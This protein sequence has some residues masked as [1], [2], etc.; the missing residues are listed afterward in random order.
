MPVHRYRYVP[1]LRPKRGERVGIQQLT[2]A[3]RQEVVPLFVLTS[4]RYVGKAQT[5]NHAAVSAPNHFVQEIETAWSQAPFYLDASALP[6]GSGQNPLVAIANRARARN[7]NLIPATSMAAIPVYQQAVNHVVN[8]DHRGVALRIGLQELSTA[9][10]WRAGWPHPLDETDLIVDV[11]AN[12]ANVQALGAGPL[13]NVFRNLH[14]GTVWRT[15][16]FVGTSMPDN[17]QGYLAGSHLLQRIEWSIW[18][19]LITPTL[20]HRLPYTLDYGDYATVPLN[21]PPTG[22][23]WG[24]PINVRYTLDGE[25]LICRGVNTTGLGAVDMDQQL[26]AH[27]QQIVAF[28]QRGPLPNCWADIEIDAIATGTA[29]AGNL[30]HWVQIGVN[31]H[32]ERVRTLLP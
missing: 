23:R 1:I 31:R 6:H 4:D 11:G 25:F 7:L 21:P 22:I 18:Q 28:P 27:A 26:I 30:E 3:G 15:V 24:F 13:S 20:A 5:K 8:A 32:I 10:T 14:Q 29:G 17:F 2:P 19:A 12:V 16:T 9:A